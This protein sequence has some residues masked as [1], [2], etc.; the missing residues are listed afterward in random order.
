MKD[1]EIKQIVYTEETIRRR[2]EELG[3]QITS[4][5]EGKELILIGV[6]KG[7]LYFFSDLTRAIDLPIGV[8]LISIGNIP[9]TTS[10]T[11]I[12]RIMKDLDL[13][14]SGKHVLLIEDI[15][16]TGLTTAYLLQSLAT[17]KPADISVCTLLYNPDRLLIN[18]PIAYYG[19]EVNRNWLVGYGMDVDEKWRNLPYIAELNR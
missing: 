7:S 6:L 12:V 18:V 2:V 4:D 16:R 10:Q 13:N 11:G 1:L 5:Y 19:F 3:K 15:L 9:D 8:D 14:I 17:R